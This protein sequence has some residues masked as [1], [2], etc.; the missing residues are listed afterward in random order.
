MAANDN[1][2]DV[3]APRP[4]SPR[5]IGQVPYDHNILIK[6]SSTYR[7]MVE[8]D[9]YNEECH[10]GYPEQ[11]NFSQECFL[12][13]LSCLGNALEFHPSLC[14]FHIKELFHVANYLAADRLLYYV[15]FDLLSFKTAVTLLS[16]TVDTFGET[17]HLTE[18]IVQFIKMSTGISYFR[19]LKRI[20]E[21][22]TAF[23]KYV[24]SESLK[25]ERFIK[26]LDFPRKCLC[27]NSMVNKTK[28]IDQ[29]ENRVMAMNCCSQ[30][31]HLNCQKKLLSKAYP[32]CPFCQS[33]YF[34]RKI[35]TE[36]GSLHGLMNR[37]LYH[38]YGIV[39]LPLRLRGEVFAKQ[40][41]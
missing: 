26:K 31:L 28:T 13:T 41:G 19:S 4:M 29:I 9:G 5:D 32:V 17:H 14:K 1:E 25:K 3:S 12:A 21:N 33:E 36:D 37:R 20:K 23:R 15:C 38:N 27:C 18:T 24:Y 16:L 2:V 34:E 6:Q 8:F 7:A 40:D 11:D 22:V 30:I 39:P 35:D 10:L